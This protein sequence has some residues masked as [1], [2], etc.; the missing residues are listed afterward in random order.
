MNGGQET[1]LVSVVI[2]AYNR[3]GLIGR[4]IDSVLQQTHAD[5]E[6]IVVDDASTDNTGEVVKAIGDTRI[7]YIRCERNAGASAARN[8]G[9]AA[10]AGRFV[11][12][13]DSD[14]VWMPE[15]LTLQLAVLLACDDPEQVVC[16]SQVIVDTGSARVVMPTAGKQAGE[17][18]GDYVF[19]HR[20]LIHTSSLVLSR[21]LAQG[22]LFPVDQRKHEDWDVFLRLEQQGVSWRFVDRPLAVWHNEPREGRLTN[23]SHDL[24][25]AWLATHRALLSNRAV[26]GFMVKE[27]AVPLAA[28]E[29]RRAHVCWLACR[30]VV[31]GALGP[32]EGM[33]LVARA[34]TTRRFR[35]RLRRGR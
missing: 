28:A 16:Y 9:I 17:P 5:L 1:P 25:L 35:E 10:A 32:G 29:Q 22:T 24:S 8:T 18:V 27:V 2:P 11:A 12:F 33:R 19:G 14:D 13:L 15:K 20:G 30:A 21:T 3:A 7:R 31:Y 34:M 6:V 23:L 26:S 4:A